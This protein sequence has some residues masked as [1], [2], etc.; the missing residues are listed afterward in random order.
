MT[1][2][3]PLIGILISIILI[4]FSRNSN[5]A[6]IYLA[7]FFFINSIYGLTHYFVTN[8]GSAF[9]TAVFYVN[10]VPL[11]LLPGPAIYFYVRS[12]LRDDYKLS[13]TDWLHFLPAI[14][15]LFNTLPYYLL[16]FDEK[17]TAA[18]A[19]M[20]NTT[21]VTNVRYLFLE[22][23]IVFLTRPIHALVYAIAASVLMYRYKYE[24][25]ISN[26]Q[27]IKI[28]NWL[29]VLLSCTILTYLLLI[30]FSFVYMSTLNLEH[31]IYISEKILLFTGAAYGLLNLS[32]FL[33]PSILY[34]LP[35]MDYQIR[36]SSKEENK[37]EPKQIKGFEISP[38]RLSLLEYKINQ[39]CTGLPYLKQDFTLQKMAIDIEVPSHHLSYFFNEHLDTSFNNWKND[40]KIEHAIQLM[41]DGSATFMTLDAVAKQSGFMSRSNFYVVFKNK[42]GMTP[43]EY[44]NAQA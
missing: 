43:T 23:P 6:N 31:I 10:F 38:E 29:K 3:V 5:K 24:N 11:Y 16:S 39:Y 25:L 28:K 1:F 27:L 32:L 13:K 37:E 22:A 19:V 14:F 9:W 12:L 36:K 34:G 44:L 33:F 35:Q 18:K 26:F 20:E 17:L 21:N 42:F 15:F 7:V 30:I 41:K 2:I 4:I 8:G 40:L